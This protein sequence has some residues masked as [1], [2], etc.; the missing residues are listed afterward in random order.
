M[1]CND[2]AFCCN[3]VTN[4]ALVRRWFAVQYHLKP[5]ALV[6]GD[7]A[8]VSGC[9]ETRLVFSREEP[10]TRTLASRDSALVTHNPRVWLQKNSSPALNADVEYGLDFEICNSICYRL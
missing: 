8:N 3:R 1:R 10:Q 4:F 6:T 2:V 9:F 5:E 7:G